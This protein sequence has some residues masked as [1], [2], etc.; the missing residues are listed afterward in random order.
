MPLGPANF[1]LH[2]NS[3]FSNVGAKL[4]AL[5]SATDLVSEVVLPGVRTLSLEQNFDDVDALWS[6]TKTNIVILWEGLD[7]INDFGATDVTAHAAYASYVSNAQSFNGHAWQVWVCTIID[8]TEFD[9]P[10]IRAQYRADFN[11]RLRADKAGA[12]RLV[13]LALRAELSDATNLTYFE[14]DGIH[15]TSSGQSV[16]AAEIDRVAV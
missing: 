12:S 1:V 13:D 6:T 9:A 11:V 15:I 2:G 3:L 7:D 4:D 10:D 5:R 14:S 8:T 16:V